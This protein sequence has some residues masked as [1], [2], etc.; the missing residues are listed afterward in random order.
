MVITSEPVRRCHAS[1]SRPVTVRPRGAIPLAGD[2]HGRAELG[3]FPSSRS[4]APA[5]PQ[6]LL[7]RRPVAARPRG[8]IPP[9]GDSHGR[10]KLG[11]FP[12]SR[13]SAPAFLQPVSYQN[14]NITITT[15]YM[16]TVWQGVRRR[17]WD[18][19]RHVE[20]SAIARNGQS[21]HRTPAHCATSENGYDSGKMT[22]TGAGAVAADLTRSKTCSFTGLRNSRYDSS[23]LN[24]S[25]VS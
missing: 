6:P 8:A 3:P 15:T 12:S 2:S 22:G 1:G 18:R 5:L 21:G 4:S 20:E 10:A 24:E 14:D 19:L 23:S 25:Q 11:P 16:C 7:T 9:P 13:S 17:S